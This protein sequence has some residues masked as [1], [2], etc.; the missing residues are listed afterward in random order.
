MLTNE[1]C[2]SA[3][4]FAGGDARGGDSAQRLAE[5]AIQE[6]ANLLKTSQILSEC[7]CV[8]CSRSSGGQLHCRDIKTSCDSAPVKGPNDVFIK[9]VS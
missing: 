6:R 2:S 3:Q 1:L 9:C 5:R 7:M 4:A 8:Q